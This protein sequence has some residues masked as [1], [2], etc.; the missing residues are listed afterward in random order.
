MRVN[1]VCRS[2]RITYSMKKVCKNIDICDIDVIKPFVTK[3][4]YKHCKEPKFKFLLVKALGVSELIY[5]V[6]VNSKVPGF[7]LDQFIHNFVIDIANTIRQRKL[8][9]IPP[10]IRIKLD[11][12]TNKIRYIGDETAVQECIDY[13]VVEA[14]K[15]LWKKRILLQQVSSIKGRGPIFGIKIIQKYIIQDNKNAW[16]CKYH[17]IPYKRKTL[18]FVKIDIRKCYPSTDKNIVWK[19][20]NDNICND[21]LLYVWSVI[22]H[23]YGDAIIAG[24][25]N[26]K[27]TGLLIGGLP[28][29]WLMQL[30]L[31]YIY[32]YA[33][34]LHTASGEKLVEHMVFFMD[35]ILLVG[36]DRNYL[37]TAVKMIINYAKDML[38]LDV[39]SDW[40]IM[41]LGEGNSS[42]DMM[43]YV[44]H[45][46]GKISI[47]PK[48]FL[49]ARRMVLRTKN[50]GTFKQYK[51]LISYKGYFDHSNCYKI[52]NIGEFFKG[53]RIAATAMSIEAKEKDRYE[54]F[55]RNN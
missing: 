21:D 49:R 39:K 30:V 42:I 14:S 17:H 32:R 7:F 34:N 20:L 35:D 45:R 5:D 3:C 41:K 25:H 6:A 15:E 46:S 37:Y 36:S 23:S 51:R 50:G 10:V 9:F 44:V 52:K 19:I 28:A 16:Y 1:G 48:I 55:F 11:T 38:H 4:I 47:R 31:S 33:K 18:Y 27:Y 26:E 40:H 22:L 53:F 12:S 24:R 2:E 29:Q 43:G 13:I 54:S 8:S